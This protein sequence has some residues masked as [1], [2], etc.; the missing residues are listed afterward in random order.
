MKVMSHSNIQRITPVFKILKERDLI[1]SFDF[2]EANFNQFI[3]LAKTLNI[4]KTC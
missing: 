3:K 1:Q 2:R 4:S